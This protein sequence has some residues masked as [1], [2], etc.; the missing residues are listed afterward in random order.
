MQPGERVDP[1]PAETDTETQ[2]A[3]ISPIIDTTKAEENAIDIGQHTDTTE[4]F[5]AMPSRS[6]PSPRSPIQICPEPLCSPGDSSEDEIVFYGRNRHGRP[7]QQAQDPLSQKG[8]RFR[9][10]SRASRDLGYREEIGSEEPQGCP[11]TTTSTDIL[12]MS[13]SDAVSH[14]LSYGHTPGT[15]LGEEVDYMEIDVSSAKRECRW[16]RADDENAVMDDYIANM[17]ND[18]DDL[19]N[20]CNLQRGIDNTDLETRSAS[21]TSTGSIATHALE[22]LFGPEVSP[23]RKGSAI[24]DWGIENHNQVSD[25]SK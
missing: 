8:S 6:V 2:D 20:I 19:L 16:T 13:G 18:Y 23:P 1:E 25:A 17:D 12:P 11:T 5:M 22:I 3:E 9:P 10:I 14:H 21:P 4:I 7:A 15:G 24:S